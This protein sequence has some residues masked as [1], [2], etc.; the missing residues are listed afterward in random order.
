MQP[1]DIVILVV[2][3]A[4]FAVAVG[5]L[6]YRK[7]KGKSAGCDYG[8]EGCPHSCSCGGKKKDK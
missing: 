4:A 2:C 6:V 7:L 5:F 3:C 1:L 8:C